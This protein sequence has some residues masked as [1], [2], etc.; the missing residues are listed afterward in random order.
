MDFYEVTQKDIDSINCEGLNKPAVEAIVRCRCQPN[1][2]SRPVCS[3][4]VQCL[5]R[6][7]ITLSHNEQTK[8]LADFLAF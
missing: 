2:C 5:S 4:C 7:G 1:K 8:I 3:G 6:C